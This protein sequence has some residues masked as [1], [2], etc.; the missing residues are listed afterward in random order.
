MGFLSKLPRLTFQNYVRK[1]LA[2]QLSQFFKNKEDFGVLFYFPDTKS[3]GNI[4]H[5]FFYLYFKGMN[6]CWQNTNQ[7]SGILYCLAIMTENNVCS[8]RFCNLYFILVFWKTVSCLEMFLFSYMITLIFSSLQVP[9]NMFKQQMHF[10]T[11][12]VF[13]GSQIS[14][15]LTFASSSY[16][17]CNKHVKHDSIDS[18]SSLQK[19]EARLI[20]YEFHLIF[21]SFK[22]VS[23]VIFISKAKDIQSLMK[24]LC[25]PSF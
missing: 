12:T 24:S 1:K 3:C 21:S 4:H 20:H 11:I 5:T 17:L 7:N 10:I 6:Y 16:N 25:L 2:T 15:T 9:V 22:Y 13:S 14:V 19:N 23:T 18:Y 8:S